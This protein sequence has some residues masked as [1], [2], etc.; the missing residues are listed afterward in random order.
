MYDVII[1]GGGPAGLAA[2]IYTAHAGLSTVLFERMSPGGTAATTYRIDNYPGFKNISGRELADEIR[3]HAEDAGALIKMEAV[4]D[5]KL[6][7]RVKQIRTA[8]GTY[9]AET[10][11]LACG[12]DRRKLGIPGEEEFAGH[13]VSYCA[14]CDGSFF[15][16]RDVAVV[17]GGNSAAGYAVELAGICSHVTLIYRGNELKAEYS[18]R[19]KLESLPN[20]SILYRH[21]VREIQG[22]TAVRRLLIENLDTGKSDTLPVA[23]VFVA[24]GIKP[25]SE[26]LPRELL[27]PDG[28]IQAPESGVTSV[29]GVFA[30]GDLRKK[31]L[32]Q[33]VTALS[34]GANAAYSAQLYLHGSS[35]TE[36]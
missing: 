21:E 17:G 34:D 25:N 33:I 20:V 9:E 36:S 18:L 15:R 5:L 7:G 1:V 6:D 32:Y 35:E 8:E 23:G 13:G 19:K 27:T 28:F 10:V 31:Q 30:A 22:D 16:K 29:P 2:A 26:L 11:I 24:I 3:A 4:S 12:S 14:A